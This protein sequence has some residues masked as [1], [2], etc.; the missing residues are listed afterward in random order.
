MIQTLANSWYYAKL[1]RFGSTDFVWVS[2]PKI[3]WAMMTI[4]VKNAG[5]ICIRTF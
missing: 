1:V 3:N 5:L 4:T 2:H